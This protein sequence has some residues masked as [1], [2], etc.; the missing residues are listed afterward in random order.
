M[1]STILVLHTTL[2]HSKKEG[3]TLKDR[4]M[5]LASCPSNI[6]EYRNPKD[7]ET[8]LL[9]RFLLFKG[10]VSLGF[11]GFELT[12]ITY[13]VYHKPIIKALPEVYFNITHSGDRV[14]CAI[15]KECRLGIDIEQYLQ[16]DISNFKEHFTSSQ[17]EEIFY[18]EQPEILFYKY[19]VQKEALLKADGRGLSVSLK[20]IEVQ[21]NRSIIDTTL[22]YLYTLDIDASQYCSWIATEQ[23]SEILVMDVTDLP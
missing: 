5:L 18:H 10:L 20:H 2:E 14:L 8:T 12:K 13:D 23:P 9:G 15:S 17:W 11:S 21:N 4:D 19:W 16:P 22:W 3:F 7:I 1:N 6:L